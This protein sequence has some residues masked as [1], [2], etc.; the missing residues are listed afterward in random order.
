MSQFKFIREVDYCKEEQ[1]KLHKFTQKK[2]E[3]SQFGV[4]NDYFIVLENGQLSFQRGQ[5]AD[6]RLSREGVWRRAWDSEER[7]EMLL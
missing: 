1:T 3:S 4:R 7:S 2:E 6:I 5:R